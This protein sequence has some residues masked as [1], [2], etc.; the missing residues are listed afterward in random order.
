MFGGMMGVGGGYMASY[1]AS[2]EASYMASGLNSKPLPRGLWGS[3]LL[4]NM[5]SISKSTKLN[6]MAIS[7]F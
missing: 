4:K 2:W 6:K 5:L 1:M 3:F 7:K